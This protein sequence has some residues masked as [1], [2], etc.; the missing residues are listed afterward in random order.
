MAL[1]LRGMKP[2]YAQ[3]IE[4]VLAFPRVLA[5]SAFL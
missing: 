4:E 1:L 2:S 3:N 5:E